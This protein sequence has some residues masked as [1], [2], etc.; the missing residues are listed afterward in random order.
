MRSVHASIALALLVASITL[1]EEPKTAPTDVI[2]ETVDASDK[3]RVI[4][5]VPESS[6]GH[7]YLAA[8]RAMS[9]SAP[10]DAEQHLSIVLQ[11]DADTDQSQVRDAQ[12][13]VALLTSTALIDAAID[14]SLKVDPELRRKLIVVNA[15][16]AG[17]RFTRLEVSL[18][19][20]DSIEWKPNDS[21]DLAAALC[22]QLKRAF[23]ESTRAAAQFQQLRQQELQQK[24]DTVTNKLA[25]VRKQI[26]VYRDAV[27]VAANESTDPQYSL[28][29][30]RQ[31]KQS[32]EREL[33]TYRT[34]LAALEPPAAPVASEWQ[35]VID[36]REQRLK[37]LKEAAK[38]G[39]D[40]TAEIKAVQ[41]KLAEARAKLA[42]AKRTDLNDQRRPTRFNEAQ[43]INSQIADIE[44]RLKPVLEGIAKL[45]DP[46][47]QE[48][49]DKLPELT[50]EEQ[51]LRNELQELRIRE[52]GIRRA[53]QWEPK[54]LITVLDGKALDAKPEK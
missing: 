39:K 51:R 44:S 1:A 13:A 27:G 40:L 15:T 30:L 26:R 14:A 10:T 36:L 11:V 31:Q 49:S 42:E 20:S 38:D 6:A 46:K 9:S 23:E 37:E 8:T 4:F 34:R 5:Y 21:K 52:D 3:A 18:R 45:E 47:V 12:G 22:D 35:Q 28:R 50:M 19:K 54:V 41:D 7:P 33:G 53:T 2:S 29:S 48:M 16:P 25:T 24:I 17:Y 32:M 43:Q